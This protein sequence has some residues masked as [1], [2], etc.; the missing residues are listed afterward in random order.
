MVLPNWLLYVR[1]E[2]HTSVRTI[3]KEPGREKAKIKELL[4]AMQNCRAG[5]RHKTCPDFYL[6]PPIAV[7]GEHGVVG[8]HLVRDRIGPLAPQASQHPRLTVFA[9]EAPLG[10]FGEGQGVLVRDAPIGFLKPGGRNQ[11]ALPV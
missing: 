6:H 3:S 4:A 8:Y 7:L 10:V 11:T 1:A 9:P 5:M 2:D